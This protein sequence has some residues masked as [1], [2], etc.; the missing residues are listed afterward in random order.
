MADQGDTAVI[1]FA[2]A[3]VPGAS[4]TRLIPA[5]GATG[6]AALHGAMIERTLQTLAALP[7]A[8]DLQLWCAPDTQHP[9]FARLAQPHRTSLHRQCGDDLGARMYHAL[10]AAL[11]DH[12]QAIIVGTD[13]P[14]LLQ[15]DI[16][17]AQEALRHGADAVIGP[18]ADGGYW[19]LG[20]RNVSPGLFADIAWGGDTVY[21]DT[22]ARLASLDWRWRALRTLA[23][24]DRPEDL[25]HVPADWLADTLLEDTR[26]NT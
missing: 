15:T 18:A 12:A 16:E 20:L 2:R 24:V 25:V 13:C 23:D 7:H 21:A 11:H 6:A 3:P 10:N 1:V 5:L 19:L 8:Y 17:T 9:L 4:K 14:G 22:V 26:E